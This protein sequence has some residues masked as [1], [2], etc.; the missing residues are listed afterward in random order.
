MDAVGRVGLTKR[1]WRA[2]ELVVMMRTLYVRGF[3]TCSGLNKLASKNG[4]K[5]FASPSVF[6]YQ[7]WNNVR[8]LFGQ[9]SVDVVICGRMAESCFIQ[10]GLNGS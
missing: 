1:G 9:N 3:A 4:S 5:S 2:R 8:G 6:L 10:V 7:T